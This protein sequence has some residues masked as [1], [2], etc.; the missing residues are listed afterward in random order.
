MEKFRQPG[1]WPVDII[2]GMSYYTLRFRAGGTETELL[3]EL[4]RL[5]TCTTVDPELITLCAQ[6][7]RT[8]SLHLTDG[9][10]RSNPLIQTLGLALLQL[11]L[12]SLQKNGRAVELSCPPYANDIL[13]YL[14]NH[15][16][17]K[18]S[19]EDVAGEF[20]QN[21]TRRFFPSRG[22]NYFRHVEHGPGHGPP[23]IKSGV[24]DDCSGS[25]CQANWCLILSSS[26]VQPYLPPS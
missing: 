3:S 7:F 13:T 6:M 24:G 9:E 4:M 19:M 26:L 8:I 23:G 16:G 20:R 5:G 11:T 21:E 14:Q 15:T 18:V 25:N 1:V 2:T 17:E 10:D 22:M 12:E